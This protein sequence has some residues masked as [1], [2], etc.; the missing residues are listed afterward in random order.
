MQWKSCLSDFA[1]PMKMYQSSQTRFLREQVRRG[2]REGFRVNTWLPHCTYLLTALLQPKPQKRSSD[3]RR[4][5]DRDW[6][7]GGANET[8]KKGGQKSEGNSK[9]GEGV[10]RPCFLAVCR[11]SCAG[12]GYRGKSLYWTSSYANSRK[13]FFSTQYPSKMSAGKKNCNSSNLPPC[14]MTPDPAK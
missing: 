3:L 13:P 12:Q 2:G 6:L 11:H 7:Q 4:R 9:K 8:V 14:Y 10:W 1:E 5:A